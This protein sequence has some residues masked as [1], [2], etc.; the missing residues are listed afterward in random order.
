MKD[1]TRTLKGGKKQIGGGSR[2]MGAVLAGWKLT[3]LDSTL[4]GQAMAMGALV[5]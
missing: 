3:T 4:K 2:S 1:R 5:V